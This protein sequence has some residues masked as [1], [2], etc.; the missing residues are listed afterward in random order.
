M[1]LLH[2]TSAETKK[3]AAEIAKSLV[4]VTSKQVAAELDK[5]KTRGLLIETNGKYQ[6]ADNFNAQKQALVSFMPTEVDLL[7]EDI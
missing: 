3:T 2:F 7:N 5:F 6:I 1:I 4:V